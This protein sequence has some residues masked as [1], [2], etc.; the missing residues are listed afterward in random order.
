MANF[1]K[2]KNYEVIDV[3]VADQDWIDAQEA[4]PWE[5]IETKKDGSLRKRYASIGG[6][7]DRDS[8]EFIDPKPYPSWVL[9]SKNE[10]EAPVNYP[11]S[12]VHMWDEA[13][14]QWDAIPSEQVA[15]DLD[16]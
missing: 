8:D 10:W 12:G 6:F 13:G 9:N 4:G 5:W 11:S 3:A 15:P 1:A 7:Y 14:Q 2:V 16:E